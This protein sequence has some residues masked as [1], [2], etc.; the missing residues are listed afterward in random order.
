MCRD[1]LLPRLP[2]RRAGWNGALQGLSLA[3][4]RGGNTTRQ[5]ALKQQAFSIDM[6]VLGNINIFETEYLSKLEIANA[7]R[8]IT[9][10]EFY[11]DVTGD[12]VF[13]PPMYNM[14]TSTDPVYGFQ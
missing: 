3:A 11:Q 9:G 8:T 5:D 2:R 13:K 14:D 1:R 10:F 4:D 6:G 7:V 12:L